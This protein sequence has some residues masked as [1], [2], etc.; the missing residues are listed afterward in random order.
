MRTFDNGIPPNLSFAHLLSNYA[1]LILVYSMF[2]HVAFFLND[3][4]FAFAFIGHF[5]P[6]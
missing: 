1:L 3:N 5:G 4:V 6:N 2:F